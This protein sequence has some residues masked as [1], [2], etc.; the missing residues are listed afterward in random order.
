M[1]NPRS[2]LLTELREVQKNPESDIELNANMDN[3]YSWEA[4]LSGPKESPYEHGRFTVKLVCPPSYPIHPPKVTFKTQVFHPNVNFLTGE[5]CLDILK[6]DWSPAW[7]LLYVCRAVIA[8]LYAPNA[9]SPLNCDAGNLIRSGDLR[10]FRS[11][12]RMYTRELACGHMTQRQIDECSKAMVAGDGRTA[13]DG[14]EGSGGGSGG[15]EASSSSSASASAGV[16]PLL[17]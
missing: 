1:A 11:M 4:V 7:T 9:E 10:G 17:S 8:L 3:L 13:F 2:R 16:P 5:V 15:G 6:T 12:A 14:V